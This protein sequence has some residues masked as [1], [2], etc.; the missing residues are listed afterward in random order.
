MPYKDPEKQKSA[1]RKHYQANK[2]K[3][4][5]RL[6]NRRIANKD[7]VN[8]YKQNNPCVFCGMSNIAC[9]DFHHTDETTKNKNVSQLVRDGVALGV[10][11]KEI[12][13]CIVVCGNCHADIHSGRKPQYNYKKIEQ[14]FFEYK[15]TLRCKQCGIRGQA[16]LAFHHTNDN[17]NGGVSKMVALNLPQEAIEKEIKKCTV[18]CVNC[19]RK[20]HYPS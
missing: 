20:L 6:K 3:F 16:I 17:K 10:L 8:T 18:L 5:E 12:D 7:Y 15:T 9:L 14:W 1:Q 13:K 19:H 4:A 11:Q 2:E